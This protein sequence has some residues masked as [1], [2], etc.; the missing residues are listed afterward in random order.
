MMNPRPYSKV[1]SHLQ[2]HNAGS[3]ASAWAGE[4]GGEAAAEGC[5]GAL[6]IDFF[7]LYGRHGGLALEL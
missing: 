2:L 4:S 7:E 6:L 5:L 3:T 1:M